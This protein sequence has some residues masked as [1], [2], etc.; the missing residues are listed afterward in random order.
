MSDFDKVLEKLL[1]E[2]GFAR[3][4]AADPG[5]ALAGYQLTAEEVSLLRTQV[6]EDAGADHAVE[7]R[8]SQSSLAGLFG[9]VTAPANVADFGSASPAEQGFGAAPGLETERGL[10]TAPGAEGLPGHAAGRGAYPGAYPGGGGESEMVRGLGT[11]PDGGDSFRGL[12]AAPDD[13]SRGL[14]T[15]PPLGGSLGEAP[16][17]PE[18]YQTRVDADGDGQWDAHTL[19]GA[20]GGGVEIH[21]DLNGD[22]QADFVGHDRDADGLVD[23]SQY[24]HDGDGRWDVRM[25][26]TNGDG[27]MDRVEDA[28]ADPKG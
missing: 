21:V 16:A 8:T 2:P 15:A 27:W 18:G 1:T 22:G 13:V 14:G 10:G 9:P 7:T 25:Y 17:V 24:D 4:L 12:G 11:A 20:P 23:W 5:R 28:D 3:A 6:S 26:D 19:H